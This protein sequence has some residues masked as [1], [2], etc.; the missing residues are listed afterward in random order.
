[1]LHAETYLSGANLKE[2]DQ[3][4][5]LTKQP[6]HISMHLVESMIDLLYTDIV[7][8]MFGNEEKN[9]FFNSTYILF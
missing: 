9:A 3:S 6:T 2:I 5:D 8:K 1:M 7:F 4:E